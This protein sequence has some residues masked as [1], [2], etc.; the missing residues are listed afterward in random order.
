MRVK[1]LLPFA[2][3]VGCHEGKTPP[4]W[5]TPITGGTM[6]ITR[7]G[8]HAIVADPDRDRILAVDLATREV[9]AEIALDAGDQ[10]G[11]LVEDG[12]GRIHV[13]LRGGGSVL[14]MNVAGEIT[15]RRYACA[16]PRGI[17]WDQAT[18]NLYV[19][20][21]TG[22]LVT[23]AAAGGEAIRGIQI[24]RDLR[25]VIVQGDQLVL[26]KFKTA[27]VL[28]VDK[29]GNVLSRV[30][31]P[32]V[33]RFGGFG[34]GGFPDAQSGDGAPP[35]SEPGGLVNAI[36]AVAWRTVALPDGRIVMSH[37]RQI[38][39]KLEAKQTGGYGAGCGGPVEAA[40]TVITP[41]QAPVALLPI[42]QAALP[43]DI[44]VSQSGDK[45]AVVTAGN[46]NVRVQSTSFA[47]SSRDQNDCRPPDMPDDPD[48][49]MDDGDD[50]DDTDESVDEGG[51]PTSAAFTPTGDLIV[52]YPE[53]PMLE[54]H[55]GGTVTQT[56]EIVM[57]TG[58]PGIDAGRH[59]FHKQ[60]P[61]GLACASC[62]PEGR[63]DGLV[64]DFAEFGKRRTQNLS[65]DILSRA[66]YHWTGDE[67]S[68][69]TLMDDVFGVRMA[70][71]TLSERQRRSLG[72]WLNR[73]PAPSPAYAAD[74]TQVERGKELFVSSGC[75]G[76]HNG[77]IL[78]NNSIVD[79]GTGGAFKVPSLMGIGAR[80]PFLHDGCAKTLT[81]RFTTC[82]NSAL[83][84]ATQNLTATQIADLVSYLET[85]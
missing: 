4:P 75:A 32:I 23:F 13:A 82:G 48:D 72:P 24:E 30:A 2:L 57:L 51:A 63:E 47:M 79:V 33:Q 80:A 78:T 43:V 81:D 74:V 31:P 16:E 25:D 62:H 38:Q 56:P 1:M 15:G 58:L 46:K 28:T 5:G 40:V 21:A 50:D 76:C 60:T 10:P 41:G 45:I 52:Y 8:S 69:P 39:D 7:T 49:D 66:P 29:D 68:L 34:G 55:R 12:A 17:A 59:V 11:R 26:T 22:E 9:T 73:L 19:A 71:G 67:A 77:S 18:D 6:L 61:T 84:G 64:W 54:I 27:E 20:C 83:H 14:T 35:P 44:A 53:K 65:G 36:A 85:L 37:Q 42:A 70:G 3:L